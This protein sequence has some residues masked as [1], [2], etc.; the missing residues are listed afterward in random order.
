ML[1]DYIWGLPKMVVPQNG[2]FIME[3]LIKTDDGRVPPFMETPMSGVRRLEIGYHGLNFSC[4]R[5]VNCSFEH[6]DIAHVRPFWPVGLC[7]AIRHGKFHTP[8]GH[9]FCRTSW[10]SMRPKT[11]QKHVVF[12]VVVSLGTNYSGG[13]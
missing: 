8:V 3:N 13:L 4:Q 9:D 11:N 10:V 12:L 7:S 5:L 1:Y 6:I 2:W